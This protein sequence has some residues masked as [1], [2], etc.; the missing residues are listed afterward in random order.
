MDNNKNVSSLGDDHPQNQ[1]VK[2]GEESGVGMERRKEGKQEVKES[3]QKEK[4]PSV[5]LQERYRAAMVLSGAGDAVG[6]YN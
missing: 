4:I 5:S 2:G 3:A 6:N 1:V